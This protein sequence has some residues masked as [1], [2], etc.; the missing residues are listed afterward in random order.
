MKTKLKLPKGW[1]LKKLEDG[2]YE[3]IH[4]PTELENG[5]DYIHV[6]GGL[7]VINRIGD[8]GNSGVSNDGDKYSTNLRCSSTELWRE[9]TKE[10]VRGL[11]EKHLIKRYGEDWKD[12][13]IKECVYLN[14][15]KALNS[16]ILNV[17]IEESLY[18]WE[19]W[20]KN[21]CLFYKGKWA[22]VLEEV[23]IIE[24]RGLDKKW[25][26]CAMD[27]DREVFIFESK[28]KK[29]N[30]FNEWY[31]RNGDILNCEDLDQSQFTELKKLN[32]KDSLHKIKHV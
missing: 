10:E 23:P 27:D 29:R 26:W 13:K 24:L 31:D 1:E 30:D 2:V 12:V 8:E 18:G 22:E 9:A 17:F 16:G 19:V 4:K 14:N 25:Q 20:S 15:S 32:W 6:L 11:F 21:G 7:I 3:V 5:K 28:P